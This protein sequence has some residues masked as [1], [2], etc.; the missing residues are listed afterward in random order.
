MA[1]AGSKGWISHTNLMLLDNDA[2]TQC[3]AEKSTNVLEFLMIR[4]R[5][6]GS[7]EPEETRF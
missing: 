4:V 7:Q 3:T 1:K 5:Y 2:T 6:A